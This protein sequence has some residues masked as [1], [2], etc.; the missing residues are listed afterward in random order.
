MILLDT[1]VILW[2]RL[3]LHLGQHARTTIDE[4]WEAGELAVSA[5]S[6]WEIALLKSL[7][8]INF[9][10]DIGLWRREQLA[11]GVIEIPLDGDIGIRA[12]TLTDFHRDPADRIIVATALQGHQLVTEDR[13]ILEWP[14]PLNRLR[15]TA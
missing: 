6:F 11:Q 12:N 8:R 1:H 7:G 2:L 4:A 9:P 15:A 14:G 3:G 13:R 10:D 5:M